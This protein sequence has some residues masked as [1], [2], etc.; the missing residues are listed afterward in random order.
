MTDSCLSGWHTRGGAE[1][2]WRDHGVTATHLTSLPP[3][4]V[5]TPTRR[6]TYHNSD[7]CMSQVLIWGH[8]HSLDFSPAVHGQHGAFPDR[9]AVRRDEQPQP[10]TCSNSTP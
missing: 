4:T 10:R 6:H 7:Q 9:P 1:R 5:S 8:S 3:Y 2:R